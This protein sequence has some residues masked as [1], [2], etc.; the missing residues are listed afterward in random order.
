M[1]KSAISVQ[2]HHS[3]PSYV[4]STDALQIALDV[5]GGS[6]ALPVIFMRGGDQAG[7]A[8]RG[9]APVIVAPGFRSSCRRSKAAGRCARLCCQMSCPNP[10]RLGRPEEHASLALEMCR[11]AYFNEE[12]MRIDGGIPMA[13]R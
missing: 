11:N 4:K 3:A 2:S 12:D 10:A 13:P 6:A 1:E 8:W 5:A 9:A 7:H